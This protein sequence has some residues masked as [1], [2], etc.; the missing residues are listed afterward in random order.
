MEFLVY[1]FFPFNLVERI[2]VRLDATRQK[3]QQVLTGSRYV[4]TVEIRRDWYY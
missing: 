4:P 3:V 2:G 1:G